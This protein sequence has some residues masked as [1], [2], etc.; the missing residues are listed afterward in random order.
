MMTQLL[1]ALVQS[2]RSQAPIERRLGRRLVPGSLTA[3]LIVADGESFRSAGWVHNISVSGIGLLADRGH[4]PG[5]I[6]QI[7]LINA[8]HTFAVA[9][10]ASVIRGHPICN[11]DH[12][13]GCQFHEPLRF[14][15]IL[16]FLL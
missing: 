15:Q 10:E 8:S 13:L 12:Y 7:L 2:E 3:C 4:L 14:E 11:G 5:T 16:P 6:V 1:P 9:V